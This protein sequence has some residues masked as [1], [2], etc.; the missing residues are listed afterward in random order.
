MNKVTPL[1]QVK[2]LSIAFTQGSRTTVAVDRVS[3][4]VKPREPVALVG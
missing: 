1:L 4:D 3:F 2:D